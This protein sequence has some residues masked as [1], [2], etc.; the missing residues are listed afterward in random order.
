M[1]RICAYCAVL[2]VLAVFGVTI[3]A[4]AGDLPPVPLTSEANSGIPEVSTDFEVPI[5]FP[6]ETEALTISRTQLSLIYHQKATLTANDAVTWQSDNDSVVK[7]DP[8]SGKLTATG[9]GTVTIT[10]VAVDGRTAACTVTVR[11]AWWQWLIRVCGSSYKVFFRKAL[12]FA[13]LSFFRI[14]R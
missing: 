4:H 13:G 2:L 3:F 10:A 5:S 11:Y 14:W 12:P 1:K 8:A 6:A 7:I 9:V